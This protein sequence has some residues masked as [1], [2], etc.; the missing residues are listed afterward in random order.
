M[1]GYFPPLYENELFYSAIARYHCH[2][3]N[4]SFSQTKMDIYNVSGVKTNVEF[5][6]RLN[7]LKPKLDLF[8]YI[9]SDEIIES[10]TFFPYFTF[11]ID[12]CLR[13]ELK[14]KLL[15]G[16]DIQKLYLKLGLQGSSV[17][18]PSFLMYCKRCLESDKRRLGE[19]YWHVNHQL[20]SSF[21]CLEHDEVLL[22]SNV[23]VRSNKTEFISIS[24]KSCG[25]NIDESTLRVI[26][27]HYPIIKALTKAGIELLK[28]KI[29]VKSEHLHIA[30]RYFLGLKGYLSVNGTVNQIELAEDLLNFYGE[31]LLSI[32]NC[33]F[34][35]GENFSWVRLITSKHRSVFH[36]VYHLL[37]QCFLNI[38]VSD[39]NKVENK[40]YSH[41]GT[42][43]FP[44]LNPAANHYKEL[45]I[46]DVQIKR[47]HNTGNPRGLF[48]CECGYEYVRIGPDKGLDDIYRYN[49][50]YEYGSVW[51]ERLFYLVLNQKLTYKAAAAELQV[52]HETV[53]RYIN[54]F[55]KQPKKQPP[56]L[57]KIDTLKER[58]LTLVNE[59]PGYSQDQI[60]NQD[61]GL[62][63]L[64]FQYDKEW[65]K[66]NS[67]KFVPF[68]IGNKRVKWVERD[69]QY[70]DLVKTTVRNIK[71]SPGKPIRVTINRIETESGLYFISRNLEN[72]PQ[73]KKYLEIVIEPTQ[74]FQIRKAKWA[75]K[76]LE[77]AYEEVSLS[78]VINMLNL[79]HALNSEL[80]ETINELI[81]ENYK[82]KKGR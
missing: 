21:I 61:K 46:N 57:S 65:L 32:F 55:K 29:S 73:I 63:S 2:S 26:I 42:G 75:I 27:N 50:V 34:N 24:Y 49:R 23:P 40:K 20:P 15:K 52:S 44:C 7:E 4:N 76:Q 58:W 54:N 6:S 60:R 18:K 68:S 64:L 48:T 53:R 13:E 78:K 3:S 16:E 56:T 11:S 22:E 36:P 80:I 39:L 79:Y 72:L 66:E 37:L 31:D 67:P 9:S 17:R 43:P 35:P 41:F 25:D 59:N 82:R 10:H 62:Y 8:N 74:D 19:G 5:V 1:L 14:Q 38:S 81:D 47:D 69:Q 51:K 33:S 28:E 45:L 12:P 77:K 71:N 70:F 30:Y